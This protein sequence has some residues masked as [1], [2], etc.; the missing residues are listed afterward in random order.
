MGYSLL[1]TPIAHENIQE[2]YDYYYDAASPSVAELFYDD[3][4]EAY[5]VLETNPYYQI[6]T[7][8]YRALPLK[9]FPYLVFFE[10]NEEKQVVKV[11]ALFHTSQNPTKWP[12]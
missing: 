6:R 9:K 5:T 2:A 3:L 8:N 11:L 4:Q 1:I 7:K 10:I 12:K